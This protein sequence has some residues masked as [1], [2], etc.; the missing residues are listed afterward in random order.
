[1]QYSSQSQFPATHSF[2]QTNLQLINQLKN[3]Y[4]DSEISEVQ[5]A[6]ELACSLFSGSFRGC[7]KPFLA[8]A[9]GT[10][11]IVSALDA[12][13]QSV[14]AALLHAAY[15]SGN[16]GIKG[17]G[18]STANRNRVRD[19]VGEQSEQLI[20]RYTE[21]TWRSAAA[22][23]RIVQGFPALSQTDKDVL[24]MRLA[25]ELEEYLD[26]GI[27]YCEDAEKRIQF[28]QIYGSYM[29]DLADRLGIDRLSTWLTQAFDVVKR[30]SGERIGDDSPAPLSRHSSDLAET[31][32]RQSGRAATQLHIPEEIEV[33]LGIANI[34]IDHSIT[35]NFDLQAM[36]HPDNVAV[37]YRNGS[38]TY[39][40]LH[41]QT[42]RLARSILARFG[43]GND[44]V[45][46]LC[47]HDSNVVVFALGILKAN[48]IWIPL[49]ATHPA[50][51]LS[52]IAQDSKAVCM[53]SD[54]TLT[55][56]ARSVATHEQAILTLSEAINNGS[57]SASIPEVSADS[58]ACV[59]YTSGSTGTPKGVIH[60]HR[61]LLHLTRRGSKAFKISPDD[62]LTLLPSCS[63]IA[64]ITDL[65]RAILNGA[66]LLPFDVREDSI[67]GLGNWL[68]D[69]RISIYHSSPT[70]FRLL[71]DSLSEHD[72]I[73]S[74]RAIHL[75]GEA[76][77]QAD[78]DLYK[79][80]FS[81]T[82]TLMNN[83]GCTELSGYRQLFIDHDFTSNKSVVPAGYAVEDIDVSVCDEK[84][85]ELP[86]GQVGEITVTSP[87]LALGYWQRP[88][89]TSA[90][91]YCS[92]NNQGTRTYRTG[93]LGYILAD[94]CLVYTGR[95][96]GQ[97]QIRGNRVDAAEIEAALAVHPGVRR[98]AVKVSQFK[99]EPLVAYV[100]PR[101][102][103][104]PSVN[105]LRNFVKT[106]LPT[107]MIPSVVLVKEL[108]LTPN[109]KINYE[110]L[111]HPV[112]LPPHSTPEHTPP[113]TQ[114]E[115]ALA[116]LW[117][118]LVEAERIGVDDDFFAL[119]GDS[120]LVTQLVN[121]IADEFGI[122]A[123][124]HDVFLH[125]TLGELA[126]IVAARSVGSAC[127]RLSD[128]E[129]QSLLKA[130]SEVEKL[131]E[132]QSQQLLQ[133]STSF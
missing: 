84:G 32:A 66:T 26:L 2:A 62:R 124:L 8:H 102:D 96:D 24:L 125:A 36:R 72:T 65:L 12:P 46:T 40:E 76:V 34:S 58:I 104:I 120:L 9:V 73:P 85:E 89:E 116:Q 33:N 31:S 94:G 106:K 80:H 118:E 109:G 5:A 14:T 23:P 27:L 129:Q 79:S 95:G 52:L 99:S 61:N 86:T 127:N 108:P 11:S 10:A 7:G 130:L 101:G 38:L 110:Q 56:L 68:V 16:F 113:R 114:T 39:R 92:E 91:F 19:A 49:D 20:L 53:L 112:T 64:G 123:S 132:S 78:V 48:K 63:Q 54:D 126:T 37:E 119:G 3:G 69:Q 88:E 59:L 70:L 81:P 122:H 128:S 67:R 50:Q 47:R 75:G 133:A 51:R 25:N 121:H 13:I 30:E 4:T 17:G 77:S 97:V 1:M 18:A 82:C 45:V 21:F 107:Y 83:L 35:H 22:I 93:D 115:K 57:A 60:S 74:V 105:E 55:D 103:D 44:P 117:S 98:V 15:M 111:G 100:V 28:C 41:E 6:Y 42:D 90:L 131:S 87:Y 29:V 43:P 71:A